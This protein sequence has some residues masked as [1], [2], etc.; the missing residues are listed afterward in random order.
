MSLEN[1]FAGLGIGSGIS[2]AEIKKQVIVNTLNSVGISVNTTDTFDQIASKIAAEEKNGITIIPSTVN[3]T[4]PEGIFDSGG[5]VVEGDVD[6]VSAN[7]KSGKTIFGIAGNSNVVD[8]SAGDVIAGNILSEKKAYADGNL[9]T[10]TI[11]SKAG[12]TYTPGTSQQQI[13]SG[14]YLSGN[15]IIDGDVDLVATNIKAGISIFGVTG[16]F[17]KIIEYRIG[18]GTAPTVTIDLSKDYYLFTVYRSSSTSY[19]MI[20][21]I[22]NNTLSILKNGDDVSYVTA[23][24]NG[25]TL[26]MAKGYS[27]SYPAHSLLA[28]KIS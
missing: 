1:R 9:I 24:I 22:N 20:Y 2:L 16:S 23:S 7:I 6:L 17:D 8:T 19:F 26:S 4:I 27:S 11:P 21:E 25:S 14:Q 15:Q 12:Q 3:Q 28:E 18:E 13:N 5:G 10:G